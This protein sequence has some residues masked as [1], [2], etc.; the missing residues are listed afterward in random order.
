MKIIFLDVDGVLNNIGCRTRTPSGCYFVDDKK[1][2][3]LKEL[4]DATGAK[5]VLSSDWRRGWADLDNG[6]ETKDSIDFCMLRDKLQEY[7]IE[8]I[9]YTMI[10]EEGYR[11]NEIKMWLDSW[12]GEEIESILILD[13]DDD[14]KPLKHFLLQTSFADGLTKRHVKRGI[15]RLK[16]KYK[17]EK[18]TNK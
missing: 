5:V 14:M 8:M 7:G 17:R 13:D 12:E 2:A 3:L 15:E 6:V 10:T 11:G 18:R 9:D 4:V 1:V 16:E